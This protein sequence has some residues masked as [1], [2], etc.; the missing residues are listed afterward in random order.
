MEGSVAQRASGRMRVAFD[1]RFAPVYVITYEGAV[2][3]ASARW[4]VERANPAFE[5]ALRGGQP[6][7][8]ITDARTVDLPSAELRAYW[9]EQTVTYKAVMQKMLGTFVVLDS[10]IL[11]GV[12]ALMT[13]LVSEVKNVEYVPSIREAVR[14]A[15]KR[16]DARGWPPVA[17]EAGS[18]RLPDPPRT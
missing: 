4:L 18:Y 8:S 16:L 17:I 2:D 13:Q 15:N 7:V 1:S 9:A 6:V 14:I 10:P 12:L 11:C 3:M 5:N